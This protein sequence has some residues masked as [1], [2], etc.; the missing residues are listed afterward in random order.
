MNTRL[1]R[2]YI[3]ASVAIMTVAAAVE[4]AM[5]QPPMCLCGFVKLW[6][7]V[8]QSSQN[9][10][11]ISDWYTPSHVIHGLAFYG[12]FSVTAR[13]LPP[14]A[15]FVMAVLLEAAWEIAENT[16]MVI[17]RYRAA[18]IALD[19]S[20][21]SVVN[22]MSDIVAMMLGFFIA[23]RL[24]VWFSAGFVVAMEIFVALLIRDNLTLNIIML[25]YPI[26]AIRQWQSG[27]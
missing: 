9:S 11:Q 8:V 25:L 4:I 7:G 19:Y 26:D 13:R 5:G 3:V 12:L 15:W 2:P 24:P 10:Q 21:D 6:H 20:G 1:W 23:H 16:P 17:N 27:G 22:S 14:R 18:T